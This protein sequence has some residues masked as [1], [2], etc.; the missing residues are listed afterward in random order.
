MPFLHTGQIT[1]SSHLF[2]GLWLNPTLAKSS[3]FG[4]ACGHVAVNEARHSEYVNI[5]DVGVEGFW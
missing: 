4:E 2:V 3:G 5:L 1:L